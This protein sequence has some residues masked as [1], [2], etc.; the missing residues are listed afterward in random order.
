[1]RILHVIPSVGPSRGGP[2]FV[3][4]ALARGL[5]AAG[6]DVHVA[7]TDDDGRGRLD[8]KS[9]ATVQDGGATYR[10]F[11]RQTRFYSVSLPLNRWLA[12][13]VA[14]YDVVHIHALFSFPSASAAHWAAKRNVPYIVRPLG[15]LNRW[16]V[17]NRRPWLKK[18]SLRFLETRILA[19]A[20]AVH[21]TSEQERLEAQECCAANNAIVIPNPLDLESAV[22]GAARGRLRSRYPELAGRVWIL[23]LSRLDPKK[24]LDLLL[25]AFARLRAACPNT[26]LIVAGDGDPGFVR[27][28]RVMAARLG[29][30]A[31]IVWTGFVA[32][33]E[34]RAALT[35][36][37]LFVLPSYSEN[38][39]VA[40]LDAMASGLPVVVSDQVA[41]HKEIAE[42]EAGLVVPC[43]EDALLG[44]LTLAVRD[45]SLRAK[46]GRNGALAARQFSLEGVV[47]KLVGLYS[48][49]SDPGRPGDE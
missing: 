10:Y 34:K 14:D 22:P 39:G 3:M 2:S 32:R 45:G 19:N 38:F 20:G 23:F 18:L 16:G 15:T 29:I 42:A 1:M 28:L 24:G 47:S 31:D 25:P 13:H 5:A 30:D 11:P 4:K 9:G 8:V 41:I 40:A 7:T 6:V 36:C 49:L 46:L 33:E 17:R 12:R 21:F 27:S 48:R 37:D 43:S 26:V 44:A 35:D